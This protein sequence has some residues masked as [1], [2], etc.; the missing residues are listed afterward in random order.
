MLLHGYEPWQKIALLAFVSFVPPLL[1]AL[2]VFGPRWY[3]FLQAR[4]ELRALRKESV[5]PLTCPHCGY[6]MR[7]SEIPRCPECGKAWGFDRT[8]EELGIAESQVID[9]LRQRREADPRLKQAPPD[10]T[11]R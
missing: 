6:N 11:P 4:R 3:R 10:A 9:H 8:F 5:R 2:V 7:G 1:L